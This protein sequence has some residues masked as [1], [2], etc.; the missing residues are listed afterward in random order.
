MSELE[1][2]VQSESVDFS[3]MPELE[4]RPAAPD[5][6]AQTQDTE[7]GIHIEA[8][9]KLE[10]APRYSQKRRLPLRKRVPLG[11][12]VLLQMLSFVLFLV[13]IVSVLALS[14]VVDARSLISSNGIK[15]IISSVMTPQAPAMR[16][17]PVQSAAQAR[18]GYIL[19]DVTIPGDVQIPEGIQPPSNLTDMDALTDWAMEL[20]KEVLGEDANVSRETVEKFLAD[21]TVS[22]YLAD[23]ISGFASDAIQGT[24]DTQ[25]TTD[26]VVQLIWDNQQVI[27]EQFGVA[28][29]EDQM[30]DIERSVDQVITDSDI[31]NVIHQQVKETVENSD[32]TIGGMKLQ[33]ILD[34]IRSVTS[35]EVLLVAIGLCALVLLLLCALSFYNIPCAIGWA[36]WACMIAGLILS[37][38]VL[39]LQLQ[40]QLLQQILGAQGASLAPAVLSLLAVM[41]PVHY[42]LFAGGVVLFIGSTA[43]RITRNGIYRNKQK[44]MV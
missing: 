28:I 37:V 21:S 33:E 9:E 36:G 41:A 11:L 7:P 43:W 2:Q 17:V 40:P 5:L 19:R 13:M 4:T 34:M 25:I 26:E 8:D 18:F 15:T 27:Q 35:D 14:L 44:A 22:D 39:L 16:R 31:N 30:K 20:T 6:F 24:T 10:Q 12:R 38:P 29:T 23:K 42:G 32:I 1:Q 3:G